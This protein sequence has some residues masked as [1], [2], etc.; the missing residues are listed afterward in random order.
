MGV[1]RRREGTGS[2]EG[3][4]GQ[5]LSACVRRWCGTAVAAR[6]CRPRSVRVQKMAR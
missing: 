4:A 2:E 1:A 6:K 5:V 3:G